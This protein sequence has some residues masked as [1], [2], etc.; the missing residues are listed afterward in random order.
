MQL[1][2]YIVRETEKAVAFVLLGEHTGEVKPMWIPLKKIDEREEWDS[3][4]PSIQIQGEGVRRL[5]VPVTLDID[6][7]FLRRIGV[8]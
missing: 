4:S 2:G 5:G 1:T 3:Y 6:N 8:A 7:E